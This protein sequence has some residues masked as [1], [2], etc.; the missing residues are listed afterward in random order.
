PARRGDGTRIE[1]RMP[2]PSCNPYL[3]FAVMLQ[4][5]LDGVANKLE[6]GPAVTKDMFTMSEREKKRL[7]IDKLPGNL[8]EAVHALERDRFVCDALGEHVSSHFIESKRQEWQDYIAMVHPW[9]VDRYI[10]MF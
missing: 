3:A 1:V 6:S 4:S 5:G 2:D 9:E 8:G 10:S 7:K